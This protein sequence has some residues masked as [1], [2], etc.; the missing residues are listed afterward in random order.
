MFGSPFDTN[1]V[2]TTSYKVVLPF[3]AY[4]AVWFII[5]T[6][7]LLFSESNFTGHYFDFNILAITHSMALGWGTMIILGA[8]HQL[9][10]VLIEG[11]LYSNKL[12]NT[13]FV[14]AGV[15]I[16]IL[17]YSFYMHE[18]GLTSE[19]GGVLVFGG[20]LA[21]FVNVLKSILQ[22]KK[23]NI[24][25][26]FIFSSI[27]W[28]LVTVG[29]GVILVFD[30]SYS[31]LPKD[32]THYLPL[33]AHFGIVGWFLLL[34]MGVGSRLIP[35]FMISKYTNKKLLR[36]VCILVNFGL[37]IYTLFFFFFYDNT[38]LLFIPLLFVLT[39]CLLFIYFCI[40]AYKGRLRRRVDYQ[41][42]FGILAA[43]MF[44]IPIVLLVLILISIYQYSQLPLNLVLTYG[45]MIFFGWMTA[46]ILGMTFKTLPFIAWN[47]AY[48]KRS[49]LGKTPNPK[50]LFNDTIF[51][52][53][54]VFYLI[55]LFIFAVGII[56]GF[57][58]LL[59]I[60]AV[61]L[62]ATAV[63]YNINVFKVMNH[64]PIEL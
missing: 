43:I 5:A 27:I 50:D 25:T 59:K 39:G 16:P 60:G 49:A 58:I 15:G 37:L 24:H 32:A 56:I 31:F 28:L 40:K 53:M 22:A 34:V 3:Y 48:R 17:V 57:T 44:V 13:S 38:I 33:H 52:Y 61:L 54:G 36:L 6:L 9:V 42:Q 10:P 47:K 23:R 1:L 2:K 63:L 46:I 26:I 20:L 30:F 8:S 51:N 55:G 35:M 45:F 41:T 29:L 7:L 11:E 19:V 12:A 64:K 4:A 14:L 62:L 18:F 21:Y